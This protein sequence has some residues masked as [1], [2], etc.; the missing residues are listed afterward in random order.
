MVTRTGCRTTGVVHSKKGGDELLFP[1][2]SKKKSAQTCMEAIDP[3]SLFKE[4]R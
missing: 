3:A 4:E 1:V 2:F